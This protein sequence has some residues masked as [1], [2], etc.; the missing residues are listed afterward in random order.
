MKLPHVR[1]FVYGVATYV[2]VGNRPRKP[3]ILNTC[4][5]GARSGTCFIASR[6]W[7]YRNCVI[8]RVALANHLSRAVGAEIQQ[9]K[10]QNKQKEKHQECDAGLIVP[11]AQRN[12]EMDG[13]VSGDC[14]FADAPREGGLFVA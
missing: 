14:F 12:C 1:R 3:A 9:Q 4:F 11:E 6:L 8:L 13:K 5:C 2:T 7:I 10:Q